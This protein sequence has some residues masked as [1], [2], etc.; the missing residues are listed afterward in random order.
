MDGALKILVHHQLLIT[1]PISLLH[2]SKNSEMGISKI[3]LVFF[4]FYGLIAQ[5]KDERDLNLMETTCKNTPNYQLCVSTISDS[6]SSAGADMEGLSLIMVAAVQ[7]KAEKALVVIDEL[8]KLQPELTGRLEQ[9]TNTY[10][11]VLKADVPEAMAGVKQ[12]V[13]KFAEFG[14]SDARW[15]ADIC[16]A[17]LGKVVELPLSRVNKDVHDL[18]EIAVAIIR[19]LL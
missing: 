11:A 17:S 13:P 1:F 3:L 10:R 15:E 18:A 4:Q 5:L 2:L 12:G 8:E 9:C 19:N 6:P 16:E 7:A 14:M